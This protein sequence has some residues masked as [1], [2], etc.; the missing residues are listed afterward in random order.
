METGQSWFIVDLV[1][2]I[3]FEYM[4]GNGASG[5]ERKAIKASFKYVKVPVSHR[6]D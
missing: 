4:M 2:S 6:C 3:P 1:G 5:L